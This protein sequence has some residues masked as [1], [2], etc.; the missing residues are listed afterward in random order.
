MN[1]RKWI[2]YT[3]T[4]PTTEHIRYVGVTVC[5]LKKRFGEHLSKAIHRGRTHRDCW[6]RSLLT[7][8]HA[9]IIKEIDQATEMNWQEKERYWIA[10]YRKTYQLV[11]HTNGGEGTPGM[12]WSAEF[13]RKYSAARKGVPYPPGRKSA[14]LGKHHTLEAI[15]KIRQAGI[16]RK[17]TKYQIEKMAAAKRGK[18]LS[19]EHIAKLVKWHTGKILT[20]EHRNKI[21]ASTKSRKPVIC[22]ETGVSYPSIT[23]TAKVLLVNEASINQS[24]RKG[25]RCRG[26][27]YRFL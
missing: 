20:Q 11:N 8:G 17:L 7:N 6:I 15:E 27:H 21:A 25:I 19:P 3:L 14:M 22:I 5:S 26:C 4:D 13:R 1:T 23:A 10:E 12:K 9:P 2:I 18:R 24:I 16:G